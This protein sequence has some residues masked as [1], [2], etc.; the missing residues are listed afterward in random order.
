MSI[1]TEQIA[2]AREQMHAECAGR[3]AEFVIGWGARRFGGAGFD[4]ALDRFRRDP[5]GPDAA[6]FVAWLDFV[7]E[8]AGEVRTLST[9]GPA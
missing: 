5:A 2:A 3:P 1:S 8:W 4:S 6:A 9:L 7:K